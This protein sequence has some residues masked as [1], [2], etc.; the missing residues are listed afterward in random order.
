MNVA[1][2]VTVLLQIFLSFESSWN[3]YTFKKVTKVQKDYRSFE[4]VIEAPKRERHFR[5]MLEV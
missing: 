5:M 3:L 2:V 4:V 1:L